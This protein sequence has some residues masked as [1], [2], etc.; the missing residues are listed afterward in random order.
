MSKFSHDLAVASPLTLSRTVND[1]V[2]TVIEHT[3]PKP[4]I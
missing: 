2:S 1:S 3:S 4:L